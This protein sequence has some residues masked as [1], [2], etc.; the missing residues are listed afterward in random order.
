[1]GTFAFDV[2]RHRYFMLAFPA[3]ALLAAHG[4]RAASGGMMQVLILA[5][6]YSIV[7]ALFICL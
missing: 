4:L 7:A 3:L 6:L 2:A 1:M 5:L